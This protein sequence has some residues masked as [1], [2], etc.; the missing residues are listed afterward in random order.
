MLLGKQHLLRLLGCPMV[1]LDNHAG[2]HKLRGFNFQLLYL[3]L[4]LWNVLMTQLLSPE[5]HTSRNPN[6]FLTA[7][8][9]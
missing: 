5:Q 2:F 1:V 3:S 6:T 8:K 9:V 7:G 4:Q